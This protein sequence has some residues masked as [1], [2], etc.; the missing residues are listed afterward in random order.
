MTTSRQNTVTPPFTPKER[1][2][3]LALEQQQ[4]IRSTFFAFNATVDLGPLRQE[5]QAL[6][7][8]MLLHGGTKGLALLPHLIGYLRQAGGWSKPYLRA[9]TSK[10]YV[11]VGG[12]LVFMGNAP[13]PIEELGSLATSTLLIVPHLSAHGPN[14]LWRFERGDLHPLVL[15][16][17]PLRVWALF[18][19]NGEPDFYH[20][21]DVDGEIG[22]S[23]FTSAVG[24]DLFT[25]LA[26]AQKWADESDDE[27]EELLTARVL[28]PM[29]VLSCLS[30]VDVASIDMCDFAVTPRGMTALGI[31]EVASTQVLLAA[32]AG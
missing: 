20:R 30:R 26:A 17:K 27:S 15:A 10:N 9:A 21:A 19:D 13:I 12:A 32:L 23:D 28:S 14:G 8:P 7:Y 4:I 25:T 6:S 29:E 2:R 24:V 3:L 31:T 11:G 1:D 18:G 16:A 5:E 22:A